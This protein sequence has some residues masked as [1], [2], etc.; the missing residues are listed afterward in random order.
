MI[1]AQELRIGNHILKNGK[2]HYVNHLTIRDIYGL[3]VDDTDNFE[4]ITLTEEW[5][6]KFG[7]GL[8]YFHNQYG[9][10]ENGYSNGKLRL[11]CTIDNLFAFDFEDDK[12]TIIKYVHNLQ[13]LYWCLCNQE[14]TYKINENE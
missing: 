5:L 10:I 8:T 2:L 9:V 12:V 14:L 7:F 3:S 6:L 1:K 11:R 4:P 13:N